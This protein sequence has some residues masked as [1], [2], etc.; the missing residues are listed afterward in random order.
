VLLIVRTNLSEDV[1]N[2]ASESRAANLQT[3]EESLRSILRN[4]QFQETLAHVQRELDTADAK[5]VDKDTEGVAALQDR[6]DALHQQMSL[7]DEQKTFYKN[8]DE[9]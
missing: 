1:K 7:T 9:E 5:E 4:V 3:A 2:E 8:N 6:L